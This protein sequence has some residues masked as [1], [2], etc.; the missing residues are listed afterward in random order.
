MNMSRAG[1][2]AIAVFG[3]AACN[4]VELLT[5]GLLVDQ[6]GAHVIVQSPVRVALALT[7]ERVDAPGTVIATLTYENLGTERV[8]VQSSYGCL[9]FASVYR[10]ENRIPFPSTQYGCTAAFSSRNLDPGAP[11]TVRWPLEIG[12]ENGLNIPA[13]QYRFVAELN[14]H[15]QNL[16]RSFI[17]HW[18]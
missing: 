6:Q 7:P 16:E 8:T 17:V 5:P 12:G 2:V 11:L 3:M 1:V 15:A 14:T 4:V 10:G 18:P 13:G 9:S